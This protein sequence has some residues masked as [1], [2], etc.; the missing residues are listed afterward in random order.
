MT[1]EEIKLGKFIWKKREEIVKVFSEFL[2]DKNPE[3]VAHNVDR[4]LEE[5]IKF[6]IKLNL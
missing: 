4:I 2:F 1:K 5:V 3:K 6:G